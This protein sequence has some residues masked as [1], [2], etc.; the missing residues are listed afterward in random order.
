MENTNTTC[1]NCGARFSGKYCNNC[2]EKV[3]TD[4]DKSIL[5]FFEEAL[6]FLTH[7]EG[8]FFRTLKVIFTRP[9]KLSLDY[10]DGLRKKYF[11]PLP[12]FMLLVVLYFI[13]PLFNG[14]N[15]PFRSF[16]YEEYGVKIASKKTRID[17]DSLY[18]TI[19]TALL[20]KNFAS[21][22]EELLYHSR[23]TDSV[24]KATP[25]LYKV[26]T[27]YN[28]KS[29]KTSKLLLLILIPLTAF[30]LWVFS[31]RKKKYFFDHLVLA[32]E[33]NSF[34]LLFT[35]FILPVI[36]LIMYKLAPGMA[37]KALTQTN[38]VLVSYSVIGI[39]CTL[40]FHLF[41]KDRWWWSILKSGII[42]FV[43]YCITMIIYKII[44]FAI[45][46]YLFT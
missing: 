27:A 14:L 40:A 1:K 17:I 2:G 20:N 8:T 31:L 39:Y 26:E 23:Y 29:E 13:F 44:L 5:H 9:G 42:A 11:K 15:M 34:F 4:H 12:F 22:D 45:T 35:F 18:G 32:T 24:F 7:F 28:K 38:I 16:L 41:Y 10:C 30:V 6:H 43:Y 25:K 3:Y 46:L 37:A 21:K 19:H 36:A 33:I